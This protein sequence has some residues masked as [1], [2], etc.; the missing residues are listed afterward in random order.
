MPSIEEELAETRKQNQWLKLELDMFRKEEAQ[1]SQDENLVCGA[2]E[3]PALVP[4]VAHASLR[5]TVS[6]P[7]LAGYFLVADGWCGL[8][9]WLLR[10]KASSVLDIGCGCGKMARLFVHHPHV[11]RYVGFDNYKASIDWCNE[12]LVPLAPDRFEFLHVDVMSQAYNPAGSLAGSSFEF[13]VP[14]ASVDLAIAA[15]LFTHLLEEDA[16]N[17]LKETR[18]VLKDDGTLVAS[19]HTDTDGTSEFQGNE[20]RIDVTVDYFARLAERCGLGL[21]RDMG[22]LLGQELLLLKPV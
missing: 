14:T 17:Y 7:S 1:F 16:V 9:N 10:K 18:R 22:L 15:S 6:S 13:P 3:I 2:G 4:P 19:L 20:I 11:S 5:R 8:L 12:F 21:D